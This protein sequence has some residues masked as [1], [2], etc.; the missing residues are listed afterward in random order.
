MI[1]TKDLKKDNIKLLTKDAFLEET[2]EGREKNIMDGSRT[3]IDETQFLKTNGDL[4]S[5]N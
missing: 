1:L 5:K 2:E 3:E 4:E